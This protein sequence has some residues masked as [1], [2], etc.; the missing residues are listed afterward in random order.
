MKKTYP[1][2][3][4]ENVRQHMGLEKNDRSKDDYIMSLEPKEVFNKYCVWEG[5][6]GYYGYKLWDVVKDIERWKTNI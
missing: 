5:L 4:M 3:I 1:S 2:Y 6:L